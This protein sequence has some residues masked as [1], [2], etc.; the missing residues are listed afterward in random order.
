MVQPEKMRHVVNADG[1]HTVRLKL[2]AEHVEHVQPKH[3][4]RP[5]WGA[6]TPERADGK[7]R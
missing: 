6:S 2:E 1:S 7:K 4:T 3:L 5:A